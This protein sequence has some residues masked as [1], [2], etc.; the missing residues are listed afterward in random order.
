M[1]ETYKGIPGHKDYEVSNLGNVRVLR[2][3]TPLG[4]KRKARNLKASLGSK[5]YMRVSIYPAGKFEVHQLVAMA[6]LGHV[7]CGLKVVVDHI[8]NNKLNNNLNNLQLLTIRRNTSKD[9]INSTGYLGV[10]LES[11]GSTNKY[12]AQIRIDGKQKHLGTF[13]TPQEASK[14]YQ[15]KLKEIK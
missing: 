12:I 10:K 7:P 1:I 2:G 14:V 5:G 13:N 8:D 6:F 4:R 11:R 15:A 9:S 3:I